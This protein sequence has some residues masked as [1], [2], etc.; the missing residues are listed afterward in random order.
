MRWGRI[1]AYFNTLFDLLG[2]KLIGVKRP[3]SGSELCEE[4]GYAGVRYDKIIYC[5]WILNV[6]VSYIF[7]LDGSD[8][9]HSL[10]G[11]ERACES[12]FCL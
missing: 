6:P 4:W 3:F 2:E 1:V 12:S 5:K 7:T 8:T 10:V 9:D 11:S